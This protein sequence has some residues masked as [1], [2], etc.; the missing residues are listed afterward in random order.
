VDTE[1]ARLSAASEER[2][3]DE[4]LVALRGL[5]SKAKL[6]D[7]SYQFSVRRTRGERLPSEPGT[8]ARGEE[9]APVH[10]FPSLTS[11]P[12]LGTV[13]ALIVWMTHPNVALIQVRRDTEN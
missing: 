1:D 8:E 13:R 9:L 3:T 7:Q 5:I 12:R 10:L 6:V 2:L 4:C 11:N